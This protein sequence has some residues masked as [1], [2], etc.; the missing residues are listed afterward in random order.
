MA[1]ELTRTFGFNSLGA[2]LIASTTY[3]P[4]SPYEQQF[5]SCTDEDGE[6]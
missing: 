1:L 2:A 6:Q 5:I 3:M 4:S